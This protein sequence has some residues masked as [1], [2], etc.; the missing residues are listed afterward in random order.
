MGLTIFF[1]ALAVVLVL[2]PAFYVLLTEWI[3]V[4]AAERYVDS[5][6]AS[7]SPTFVDRPFCKTLSRY[8]DAFSQAVQRKAVLTFDVDRQLEDLRRA[9]DSIS[10]SVRARA[11]VLILCGL[12]VTLVKLQSAVGGLKSTFS[13]LAAQQSDA[14]TT[15]DTAAQVV[16]GMSTV[17]TAARE[18]FLISFCAISFAAVLLLLALLLHSKASH[19]VS[20]FSEWVYDCYRE[21][22]KKVPEQVPLNVVAAEFKA[23]AQALE[24]LTNSFGEMTNSFG[25]LQG[26]ADSTERSRNAIVEA[27]QKLPSHIQESV[28]TLSGQFVSSVTDGLRNANEHTNQILLIYGQ[29]QQRIEKIQAEVVAIRNFTS[30][31]TESVAK[32]HRMPE[33]VA[34]LAAGVELQSS[35]LKSFE[36]TVAELA[37]RVEDLPVSGLREDVATLNVATQRVQAAVSSVE[38]FGERVAENIELLRG[39]PELLRNIDNAVQAEAQNAASLRVSADALGEHVK[40]VPVVE[41]RAGIA[42]LASAADKIGNVHAQTIAALADV[43]RRSE[44][45]ELAGRALQGRID[46][47]IKYCS[48]LAV[49]QQQI[50]TGLGDNQQKASELLSQLADRLDIEIQRLREND[51][52]R[53]IEDA[54]VQLA[55]VVNNIKSDLSEGRSEH[56]KQEVPVDNTVTN[57]MG[58]RA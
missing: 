46:E 27:M 13:N 18:A 58:A 45:F 22:L 36:S 37:I 43:T 4:R 52:L 33:H 15:V 3:D 44:A 51:K 47:V 28:G 31:V 19:L 12:I 17:A 6:R 20:R 34:A 50:K 10:V 7:Q 48:Q 53:G 24:R 30:Q 54:L 5:V 29:Q 14:G 38:R 35:S 49:Q 8:L 41:L 2:I 40:A 57:E 16:N 1:C 42:G 23:T 25:A 32:L 55:L 11:G 26:F 56:S 39:L 21:E 9:A